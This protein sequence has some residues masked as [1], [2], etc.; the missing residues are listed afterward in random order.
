[1]AN[2]SK[3]K[4]AIIIVV[5]ILLVLAAVALALVFGWLNDY[6]FMT[7]TKNHFSKAKAAY[8][9]DP[10]MFVAHRGLSGEA[11]QNTE[12]TFRLAAD[13]EGVWAIETDVWVTSD[14]GFVCMHDK[15]ALKG[16]KDVANIT[17]EEALRTPLRNDESSFAPSLE[18]YL[19]ICK[20]GGKVALIELKDKKMS[21]ESMDIL[22]KRVKENGAEARIISFHYPLLEYIRQQD[23]D[24]GLWY[25]YMLAPTRDVPG[26]NRKQRLKTIADMKMEIAVSSLVLKKS[27]V[28]YMHSRG[29]LVNVWT[30]NNAKNA[31]FFK[32]E[33]DVDILTSDVRL[34]DEVQKFFK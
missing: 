30:V 4:K 25:I 34:Y 1:M 24:I 2:L 8:K 9:D 3:G 22:L 32:Y 10:L 33:F 18:T 13:Y 7:Y 19:D 23:G 6:R 27:D 28:D 14:G 16:V 15:N 11:F 26:K 20:E 5:S 29:R 31:V 21:H 17:L 12:A